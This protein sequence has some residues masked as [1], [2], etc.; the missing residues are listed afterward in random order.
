MDTLIKQKVKRDLELLLTI[1]DSDKRG[2]SDHMLFLLNAYTVTG[3][4]TSFRKR[5]LY[6]AHELLGF[7]NKS[8]TMDL[9]SMLFFELYYNTLRIKC[10]YQLKEK[11]KVFPNIVYNR[12]K[13]RDFIKLY[14]NF[15]LY[16]AQHTNLVN[17]L[18]KKKCREIDPGGYGF[19]QLMHILKKEIYLNNINISWRHNHYAYFS[20]LFF[21]HREPTSLRIDKQ[22]Y[23]KYIRKTLYLAINS[24]YSIDYI[25]ECVEHLLRYGKNV[26]K[27]VIEY[28]VN[29]VS[30]DNS[31]HYLV[32]GSIVPL[33]LI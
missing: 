27:K 23:T 33:S 6:K 13:V 1:Q 30:K 19:I 18:I 26:N 28:I 5:I 10:K 7:Y 11:C 3:K 29:Y 17:P 31:Y 8:N 4:F 12:T 16:W 9:F 15:G 21:T 14:H 32:T 20:T 22:K 2:L 25:G 24:N